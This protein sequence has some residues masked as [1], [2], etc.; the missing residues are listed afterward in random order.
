MAKILIEI[1]EEAL[2]S[3]LSSIEFHIEHLEESLPRI[4]ALKKLEPNERW[5][6][7]ED[8]DIDMAISQLETLILLKKSLAV[9]LQEYLNPTP[10]PK[11]KFNG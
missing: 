8:D 3:A 11:A 2:D 4:K 6:P 10:L 9:P 7:L 5:A 1:D